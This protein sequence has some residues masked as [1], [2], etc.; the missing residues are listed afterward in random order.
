MQYGSLA[1]IVSRVASECAAG[2]IRVE[3]RSTRMARRRYRSSMAC[4]E[5]LRCRSNA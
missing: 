4:R 1:A 3:L 5:P 2:H